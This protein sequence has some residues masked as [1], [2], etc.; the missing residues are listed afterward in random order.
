[1]IAKEEKFFFIDFLLFYV[2]NINRW[3]QEPF[4]IQQIISWFLLMISLFLVI[5]GAY[6]LQVIGKPDTKRNESSLFVIEKTTQLVKVG[7]YRYIR[8]PLYSSLLFLTW[9]VFYKDASW[10]GIFLSL[11]A[12]LCLMLTAKIEEIENINFFGEE[13]RKYMKETKRFIP[14]IF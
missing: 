13:Y 3:F 5:H 11:M 6:L 8:H 7:A 12:T 2:L 4:S 9:G 1:M 10:V 14:Y